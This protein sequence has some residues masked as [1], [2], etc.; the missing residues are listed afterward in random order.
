MVWIACGLADFRLG[1]D[2]LHEHDCLIIRRL[3]R[4]YF[5]WH[6]KAL[7]R[8]SVAPPRKQFD[9]N[10]RLSRAF[11]RATECGPKR[12]LDIRG[13]MTYANQYIR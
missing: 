6:T 9:V 11:Q 8:P 12:P 13:I 10:G 3:A 7:E 1:F 5:R 2:H 4:V